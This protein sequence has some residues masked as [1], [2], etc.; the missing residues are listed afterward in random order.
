MSYMWTEEL[1]TGHLMID[2]Q[3]KQLVTTVNN[4]LDA[5]SQGKGREMLHKTLDFLTSYTEKHFNDEEKLQVQYHYPDY[6]N[7]K[8]LHEQFKTF[9]RNLADE[10]KKEGPTTELVS[11]VTSGVGGW[12]INH[13]K[14]ED[15]KVAAHIRSCEKVCV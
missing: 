2:T 1:A 9:V 7:H 10:I 12:L 6:P 15:Q 3:H 4:L 14:R 5:C 8:K 13:I 11:K